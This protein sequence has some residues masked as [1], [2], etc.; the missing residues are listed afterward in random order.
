MAKSPNLSFSFIC[1]V[2]SYPTGFPSLQPIN[3]STVPLALIDLLPAVGFL[4]PSYPFT[5]QIGLLSLYP[6][7]AL[8]K[9]IGPSLC[10][11]SPLL[12]F[13]WLPKSGFPLCR[14]HYPKDFPPQPITKTP[15]KS[16]PKKQAKYPKAKL[17]CSSPFSLYFFIFFLFFWL[18]ICGCWLLRPG[19]LFAECGIWKQLPTGEMRS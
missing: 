7:T 14:W 13:R 17:F 9:E 16:I 3:P 19:I 10:P 8:I 4:K 18:W 1:H 6:T 15:S 2:A 12:P 11:R 5:A